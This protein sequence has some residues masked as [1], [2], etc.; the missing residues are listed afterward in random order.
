[1][2]LFVGIGQKSLLLRHARS[3]KDKRQV[4]K[5]IE[6]KL[7]NLGFSVSECDETD[8]P[9]QS[10]IGF[11]IAGH[12][13]AQVEKLLDQADRLFY[14]ER[15]VLRSERDVFDYTEMKQDDFDKFLSEEFPSGD[16]K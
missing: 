13:A 12:D 3:L 4:I 8:N 11:T 9:T 14:G 1:M 2:A 6:A 5:S 7:K 10:L 15:E 16:E